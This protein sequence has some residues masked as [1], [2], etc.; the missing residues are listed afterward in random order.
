MSERVYPAPPEYEEFKKQIRNLTGIDLNSYKY[1]IHRRV[2]MLM[3]R[4]R[5]DDYTA[6]FRLLKDNEDRLREFLDYLTINVSEFF[7][8]PPRWWEIRDSLIPNLMELRKSKKLALWSA[9][10]ATGE[11][12]Y[13]LGI[14]SA[15]IGLKVPPKVQ[16]MDIDAGA[17]A[18][19]KKGHYLKR[20]LANVP[21]EW[22]QRHLEPVEENIYTVKQ[23]IK[24]RVNFVRGNL[25]DDAFSEEHFD[26]I[27][28]R[29]VVIYFSPETK[30]LLYRKFFNALKPGGYLVVGSTEQIFEYRKIGF[31]SAGPF[32]YQ[33]PR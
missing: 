22:L 15:E 21:Q 11:E 7:R 12:P 9:G 29:N 26:M 19:A 33:R 14:L 30:S 28:C 31:A 27:L 6:F 1:Q 24:D 2:H 18:K 23:H 10:A 8:N 17:L 16:A 4:W 3:Q 20:Q 5:I 32:L 13:S 25:I